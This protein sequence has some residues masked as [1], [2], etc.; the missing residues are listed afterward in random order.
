MQSESE[1]VLWMVIRSRRNQKLLFLEL[2]WLA[3]PLVTAEQ[4]FNVSSNH[5][6]PSQRDQFTDFKWLHERRTME[7]KG[8]K[9]NKG[10]WFVFCLPFT[11]PEIEKSI[12]LHFEEFQNF[13]LCSCFVVQLQPASQPRH[14]C[15]RR[16]S[17][18]R[19]ETKRRTLVTADDKKERLL[20]ELV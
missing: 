10:K 5:F 8:G 20:R 16:G 17:W 15:H 2:R 1:L 3:W 9:S 14:H 13:I 6:S 12:E 4:L 7:E 19:T 11:P 18:S